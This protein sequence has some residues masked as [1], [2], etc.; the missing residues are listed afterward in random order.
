MA[1]HSFTANAA[2]AVLL[3]GVGLVY[4]G[5]TFF[6]LLFRRGRKKEKGE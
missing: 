1:R 4:T 2:P 5:N 3:A 6:D